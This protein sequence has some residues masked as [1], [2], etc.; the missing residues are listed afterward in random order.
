MNHIR[1]YLAKEP[2]VSVI[3]PC[4]N[5]S[6]T[7]CT[8]IDSVINQDYKNLE[9]IV[10]DDNSSDSTF[11]IVSRYLKLDN[12]LRL[13]KN[14]GKKGVSH[15]RNVGVKASVG[16]YICFLDSDDFLLQSSIKS[17]VEFAEKNALNLVFGSYDR[18]FS[19]GSTKSVVPPEKVSYSDMLKRN[20][21]GNLTGF[22]NSNFFGKIWQEDIRHEDYLMWCTMLKRVDFAYSVGVKSLGVYRVSTSSLSG[23]KLKAFI[24]HWKVLRDGLN[25]NCVHATFYQLQYLW[26]SVIDRLL[27]KCKVK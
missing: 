18:L 16:K 27:G 13:L 6:V 19:N 4:Y 25:I 7:V 8:A 10:V 24:W 12:R 26:I 22:Y 11:E 20:Y 1:D 14:S 9:L 5:S 21:I 15:S 3:M 2:L 23:N 17:R